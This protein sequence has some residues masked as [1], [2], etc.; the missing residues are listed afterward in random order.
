MYI[1]NVYSKIS[2]IHIY[3]RKDIK[4]VE[5]SFIKKGGVDIGRPSDK[6]RDPNNNILEEVCYETS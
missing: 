6:G 2:L 5:K 4:H 1:Y 3:I